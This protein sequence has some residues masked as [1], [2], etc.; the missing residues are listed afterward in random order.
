MIF[1]IR[2]AT[3]FRFHLGTTRVSEESQCV[4][5]SRRL[6]TL[7]TSAPGPCSMC[8]ISSTDPADRF[9]HFVDFRFL[10]VDGGTGAKQRPFHRAM[11]HAG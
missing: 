1:S 8:D 11:A 5:L 7:D 6:P 10:A 9:H 4:V 3:V 2:F